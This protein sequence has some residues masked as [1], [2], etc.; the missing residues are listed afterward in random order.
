VRVKVGA[1]TALRNG[2][3]TAIGARASFTRTELVNDVE[4][5]PTEWIA[6]LSFHWVNQPT[7]ERD[8]R[9]N[10]LGMEITDY[11]ADRDLG[12]A[13]RGTAEPVAP[14]ASPRRVMS[15]MALVSPTNAQQ[16]SP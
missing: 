4:E 7:N 12:A 15:P 1:I 3:G 11:T 16:V 5:T 13:G 10:D 8:R 6:N 14:K 2:L 9:I